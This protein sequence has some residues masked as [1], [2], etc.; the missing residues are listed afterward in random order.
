VR[1]FFPR[2]G[3]GYNKAQYFPAPGEHVRERFAGTASYSTYFDVKR[4]DLIDADPYVVGTWDYVLKAT[5]EEI[6]ALPELPEAGDRVD[7]YCL[8]QEAKWL[9]GFWLNRGSAA[10]K[11]TRT[12]Y[13]LRTERKQLIWGQKAKERI[14]RQLP[15]IAGWTVRQG[16]YEDVAFDG[17]DE[18][19]DPPYVEQGHHYPVR[20]DKH[21]ALGDFVQSQ[22]VGLAMVCEGPGATWLPFSPLGSLKS[23]RGRA[24]EFAYVARDGLPLHW[25]P[26]EMIWSQQWQPGLFGEAT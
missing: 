8:P 16:S 6:M 2:Y 18:F 9:I 21:R 1:P 14:A 24:D 11:K 23:S 7:N 10:P 25:S 12:A 3:A 13:S 20:F 17:A 26:E 19:F 5:P 4:A 22:R 15:G